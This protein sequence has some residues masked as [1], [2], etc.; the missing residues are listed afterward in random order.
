MRIVWGQEMGEIDRAASK[1]YGIPGIV[2]MENA[3]LQVVAEIKELMGNVSNKTIGIY[4][5]KGNNGGDG[6]VVARH[7]HNGGAKVKVFLLTEPKELT[8]D[9]AVN[10][11]IWCKMGQPIQLL[12]SEE[13]VKAWKKQNQEMD[14]IVDA[15]YG[16]GFHGQVKPL[17][18]SILEDINQAEKPVVAVDI[19][20]GI[21]ADT[22]KVGGI[23]MQATVTV[24]FALPK[25]GLFLYPG[26]NHVGRLRVADISIPQILCAQESA[27][28]HLTTPDMVVNWLPERKKDIHKGSCGKVLV[29][30]GSAGMT[31]A[32]C[33]TAEAAA[34]TG[35]GLVTLAVPAGVQNVVATK[36][37]EVMSQ[38]LTQTPKQSL[39]MTALPQIQDLLGQAHVLALGPGLSSF[40]ETS[41]L[42]REVLKILTVPCVLDADGLNAM[43][44]YR[45]L[46]P[47]IK[48][49]LV[50]TPHLGE[51]ARLTGLSLG[52][53]AQDR[54]KIA[55]TYAAL[56]QV[57][58]VLKGAPTIIATPQRLY[59]NPTGNPGMATG[60]S[61]DVLT[62]IIASLL[63]QGLTPEEAG[64]CGVYL[65]GLAGDLA[66]KDQGT[67]GLLAGDIL[68]CLPK[69]QK[70]LRGE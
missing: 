29:I 61:G 12:T 15:I 49:P 50:L 16:T 26:A 39:A 43:E 13:L 48:A 47:Q 7:L 34:R 2:L 30:A 8:G 18:H 10:L 38:G 1:E 22:G 21:E 20:S 23:C 14:L 33:L 67:A 3:G 28:K 53:I 27:K 44:G 69:A 5:G 59:I 66:A 56:W 35:S 19:P 6:L 68:R 45:A 58:L 37:T 9:A 55:Q 54:P 42:I 63:G 52:E 4:V 62:G 57:V 46:W 70:M 40:P 11:N 31:G 17:V 41:H 25:M 60:G 51:M 32:A 24:T 64:V 36:L 65:H